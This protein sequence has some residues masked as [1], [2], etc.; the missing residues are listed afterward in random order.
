MTDGTSQGLFIV[1]AI[2][3][4]GI[5]TVLAYILF[6]DT[7]SPAMASMFTE[8]TEKSEKQLRIDGRLIQKTTITTYKEAYRLDNNTIRVVVYG[9]PKT[10]GMKLVFPTWTSKMEG[11][12]EGQYT[13][14][15]QDDIQPDWVNN[16]DAT[17]TYIGNDTWEYVFK[18]SQH[19]NEF[20]VYI[21][22]VY[23]VVDGVNKNLGGIYYEFTRH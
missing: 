18:R 16:P 15:E 21:T 5:F 4:F 2:V 3:I 1:V 7:L 23:S 13:V 17:G 6:E 20:G 10:D 8:A 12:I 19:K 9:V 14:E 11:A 22:H